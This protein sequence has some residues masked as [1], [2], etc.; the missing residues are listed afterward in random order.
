MYAEEYMQI[1]ETLEGSD[2]LEVVVG[3]ACEE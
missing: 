2:S 3:K 1:R